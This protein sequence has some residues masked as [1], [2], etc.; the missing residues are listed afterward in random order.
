M[1]YSLKAFERNRYFYGKLLTVRDFDTEQ[2]YGIHKRQLINRLIHGS[3]VVCGL[4]LVQKGD[5]SID[6]LPGVALDCMGQEIIVPTRYTVEHLLS[7]PAETC[8]DK[9]ALK[10]YLYLEYKECDK[11]RIPAVS[12]A[13]SCE[14]ICEAN[15]VLE[16]FQVTLRSVKHQPDSCQICNDHKVL[17]EKEGVRL[18]RIAPLWVKPH[19]VFTVRLQ[20]YVDVDPHSKQAEDLGTMTF[21]EIVED[22][23]LTRL[24]PDRES[25]ELPIKLPDQ[26]EPIWEHSYIVQAGSGSGTAALSSEITVKNERIPIDQTVSR[27]VVG[28]RS[29]NRR[30][31][32][33]AHA[34]VGQGFCTCGQ[35]GRGVLLGSVTLNEAGNI[36]V[37]DARMDRDYVYSNPMLY[38][39]QVKAEERAGQLPP[40]QKMHKVYSALATFKGIFPKEVRISDKIPYPVCSETPVWISLE[41]ELEGGKRIAMG[42]SSP[43]QQ[44][45]YPLLTVIHST[46]RRH[47]QIMLEDRR[48]P[49]FEEKL[50]WCIRWF[51]MPVSEEV[52]DRSYEQPTEQ[53]DRLEQRILALL[54]VSEPLEVDE[55]KKRLGEDNLEDTLKKMKGKTIREVNGKYSVK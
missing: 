30:I 49:E 2:K 24:Y 1:E 3:G 34:A 26:E 8:H 53:P 28:E 36:T 44:N 48:S 23:Y 12:S 27:V 19:D 17:Y 15:R 50:D 33:N 45:Y 22:S 55:I 20:L 39:L 18:I 52:E 9:S 13:S 35:Q 21:R 37:I 43:L 14:E 11:E 4:E 10:R 40:L 41:L 46:C 7:D 42:E 29:I 5:E 31:I 6:V 16:G 25:F 51:A 47:F 38:E 32:E 54:T